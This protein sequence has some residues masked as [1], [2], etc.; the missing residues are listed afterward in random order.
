MNNTEYK[1][2]HLSGL[3]DLFLLFRSTF[4]HMKEF[5]SVPE[6]KKVSPNFSEKLMLAVTGVNSC[7]NCSY[8]HTKTAL[9][10]GVS[11]AE[12]QKLLSCEFG[13]FSEE[14]AV[15]LAYAEHWCE[16]GGNP[17]AKT[18]QRLLNRYGPETTHSIE[19]YIR[20]IYMGNLICNTV[21]AYQKGVR[22]SG[23]GFSFFFTF[24]FCLPMASMIRKR[25]YNL[26]TK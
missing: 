10:K 5:K 4:S 9:E 19:G 20:M 14:E 21:E 8:L 15:G 17:S 6:E 22:Y 11:Q 16:T 12:I 3:K 1:K 13:S 23:K 26:K 24:L 2:R 18:R 7:V 25:S